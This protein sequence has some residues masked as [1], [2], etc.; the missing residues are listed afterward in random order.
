[1][2][3]LRLLIPR[4]SRSG[5]AARTDEDEFNTLVESIETLHFT[6]AEH[7]PALERVV[8]VE[9]MVE[10]DARWPNDQHAC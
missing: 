6:S 8:L 3:A 10:L 7:R 4:P 2:N 5:D 1:M 9:S